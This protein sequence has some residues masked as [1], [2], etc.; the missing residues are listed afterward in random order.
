[1]IYEV[2]CQMENSA[3]PSKGPRITATKHILTLHKGGDS[4]PVMHLVPED[5]LFVQLKLGLQWVLIYINPE[6]E[7]VDIIPVLGS[8]DDI[9]RFKE[10]G[11]E[12][13]P[14]GIKKA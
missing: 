14:P 13:D 9:Q 12:I 11:A 2:R 5:G 6:A 10:M 1:M 8:D 3:L 4:E 7:S